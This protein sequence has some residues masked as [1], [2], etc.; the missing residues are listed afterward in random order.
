MTTHFIYKEASIYAYKPEEIAIKRTEVEVNND[1]RVVTKSRSYS[2]HRNSSSS[3]SK[4]TRKKKNKR[5]HINKS[6]TVG[7]GDTLSEIAER[8]GT[9]VSKLKKLNKIDGST[10]RAGKKIKVK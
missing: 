4:Y 6:V 10:I 7:N 8:H 9:T 3:S 5:K 1:E 2:R